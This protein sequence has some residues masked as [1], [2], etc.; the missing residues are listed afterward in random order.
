ML[1]HLSALPYPLQTCVL[2]TTGLALIFALKHYLADFIL[3]TNGIARG[4]EQRIGWMAPLMAHGTA[5]AL[6]TLTV[7]LALAPHLWWLALVDLTVHLAIDRAKTT[8]AAWGRWAPNQAQFWWLLGFDQFL[9]Q[10][11]NVALAAALLLL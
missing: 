8:T 1:A 7:A 6:L 4:K 10:A 11:T 5:H 2:A 9:H 3:Q